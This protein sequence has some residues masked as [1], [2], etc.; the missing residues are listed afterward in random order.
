MSAPKL[1]LLAKLDKTSDTGIPEVKES[2]MSNGES[3]SFTNLSCQDKTKLK[4]KDAVDGGKRL[5][6]FSA[7]G[8]KSVGHAP[9]TGQRKPSQQEEIQSNL[10]R[11]SVASNGRKSVG[12]APVTGQRKPNQQEEI[13]S[14]LL[15]PKSVASN[16]NSQ[17][18]SCLGLNNASGFK[19]KRDS[20]VF[21]YKD[22]PTR[23]LR[24]SASISFTGSGSFSEL[25]KI[26][27]LG[28][29]GENSRAGS[30]ERLS[31]ANLLKHLRRRSSEELNSGRLDLIDKNDDDLNFGR[32]VSQAHTT[33]DE[34]VEAEKHNEKAVREIVRTALGT[35]YR[36]E[37]ALILDSFS[38]DGTSILNV[39]PALKS[40][41]TPIAS[42]VNTPLLPKNPIRAYKLRN[43]MTPF[44][45][46]RARDNWAF[47][48]HSVKKINLATLLFRA[49]RMVYT[50]TVINSSTFPEASLGY[51][52]KSFQSKGDV[53]FNTKVQMNLK[54]EVGIRRDKDI[55]ELERMLSTRVHSF[56]K[57]S[58]KQRLMLCASFNYLAVGPGRV[59]IKEGHTVEV[60]QSIDEKTILRLSL[61][62]KG[63]T[64]G[65]I[66][67]EGILSVTRTATVTSVMQTELLLL[68]TDT[69]HRI[70]I[71]EDTEVGQ[72]KRNELI[73]ARFNVILPEGRMELFRFATPAMIKLLFEELAGPCYQPYEEIMEEYKERVGWEEYKH[74][75]TQDLYKH[76][77]Y[78]KKSQ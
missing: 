2:P 4:S 78:H 46:S 66:G 35:K 55:K 68:S 67:V 24:K 7:T 47:S 71:N 34:R 44:Q 51:L 49:P 58:A 69:Y 3:V 73:K 33:R 9:V 25:S 64:F 38:G 48:I 63:D 22:Q 18:S 54:K 28:G 17:A 42:A 11:K 19:K 72:L 40:G 62:N 70:I 5:S 32:R 74:S 57:Y 30:R 8:R 10:R 27:G 15:G 13:Q 43:A 76:R 29:S 39:V 65:E 16:N 21:R 50:K 75:V 23:S 37:S 53:V 14:N 60:T 61:L 1:S 41:L 26:L 36:K 56:V 20:I 77:K 6:I 52:L 45:R 31:E 12:H 59:I